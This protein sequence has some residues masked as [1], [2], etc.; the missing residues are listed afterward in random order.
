MAMVKTAHPVLWYARRSGIIRGPFPQEYVTRYILLGRIR[1][2]DELSRTGNNWR[3][4]TEFPELF[5]EEL[6]G[7]SNRDNYEKLVMARIR[8]DERISERRRNRVTP[9]LH[10]DRRQVPERRRI[11]GN[12]EYFEY[13]LL[14][15]YSGV[16]NISGHTI[17]HSP[18]ILFLA[19]L[20]VTLVAVYV[21]ISLR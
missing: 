1:L 12:I 4:V 6:H 7:L 17:R 9:Q 10:K 14:D 20:L 13:H 18:R 5:P 21:G 15:R 19:A 2:N 16:Q 3:P 11:D 8:Y